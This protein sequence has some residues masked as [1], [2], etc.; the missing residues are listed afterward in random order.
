[1]ND[2]SNWFGPNIQAVLEA[3]ESAGFAIEVRG[4]WG[5]RAAFA[6]TPRQN[7]LEALDKTYEVSDGN[8]RCLKLEAAPV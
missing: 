2:W 6:A 1:M 5:D 3:F 8:R 7:L 4:R